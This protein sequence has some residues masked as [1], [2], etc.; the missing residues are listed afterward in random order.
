MDL[1][2]LGSRITNLFL[3]IFFLMAIANSF[4]SWAVDTFDKHKSN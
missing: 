4:W 1:I 3:A 2:D